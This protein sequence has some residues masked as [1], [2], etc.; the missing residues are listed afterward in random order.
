L[1]ERDR[2]ER[3]DEID[4]LKAKVGE[5]TMDNEL[6]HGKIAR[7]EAGRPLARRRSKR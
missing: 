4:R 7:L 2:D 3:D 1:K 6:L 5:I